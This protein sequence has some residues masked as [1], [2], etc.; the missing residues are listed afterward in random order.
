MGWSVRVYPHLAISVQNYHHLIRIQGT[1]QITRSAQWQGLATDYFF[2]ILH[3]HILLS[4]RQ[5]QM[6]IFATY[7]TGL[8]GTFPIKLRRTNIHHVD[9][10]SFSFSSWWKV[11]T[12]HFL[13][14]LSVIPVF[15]PRKNKHPPL[16]SDTSL[17]HWCSVSRTNSFVTCLSSSSKHKDYCFWFCAEYFVHFAPVIHIYSSLSVQQREGRVFFSSNCT[18]F[19]SEWT[20]MWLCKIQKTNY[21]IIVPTK[22]DSWTLWRSHIWAY[23]RVDCCTKCNNIIAASSFSSPHCMSITL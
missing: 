23:L 13:S 11:F 2:D 12:F 16:L 3:T 17:W 5:L 9:R 6:L 4:Q 18:N 22:T 7:G 15:H 8:E 20:N 19:P 14:L 21:L 10:N 1:N